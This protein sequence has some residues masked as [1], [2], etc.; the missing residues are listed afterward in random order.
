[1]RLP[2]INCD[3]EPTNRC[4]ASCYF[5]PRD[6][7]PHQGLMAPETFER[8]LARV[9]EFR[10]F[11]LAELNKDIQ[12]SLCGLGEALLNKHTVSF[13]RQVR[14]AGLSCALASNGALLSE[15]VARELLDAGLS[16]IQLNVGERDEEYERIY[17][18]PWDRTLENVVR[19]RELAGEDCAAQI[20]LVNHRENPGHLDSMQEFWR[21]HGFTEF[22]EFDLINRGGALFVDHM[23]YDAFPEQAQ[24]KELLAIGRAEPV[25]CQ[26]PF[27]LP[28]IGYDGQYYLCCSDWKKE[29]PM[30]RVFDHSFLDVTEAKLAHVST[31]EPVCKSCNHDPVNRVTE[32]LRLISSAQS[33]DD[34]LQGV[35]D[36]VLEGDAVV[37]E[38]V[39]AVA[40]VAERRPRRPRIPLEVVTP[41]S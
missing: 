17:K 41:E 19:F 12:V 33:G 20:V 25:V 6:Q 7:T 1:M 29:A 10:P 2:F 9:L 26:A 14:E 39:G 38:F 5:C 13:V 23:Q 18:L 30:G 27:S 36:S 24:A 32:E 28:F 8:A 16:S 3:I 35:L 21:G 4:N 37:R 15:K 31:R 34:E 40:S 11:S 22:V